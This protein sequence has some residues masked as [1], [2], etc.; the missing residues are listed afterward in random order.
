MSKS[1]NSKRR[2]YDDG[3]IVKTKSEVRKFAARRKEK[4]LTTAI[5]S[6]NLNMLTQLEEDFE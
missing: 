3:E 5:K 2:E 4:R 6:K 1:R